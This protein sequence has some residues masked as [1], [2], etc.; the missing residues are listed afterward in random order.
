MI[1]SPPGEFPFAQYP[2]MCRLASCDCAIGS[3]T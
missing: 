3:C 2:G 1:Y